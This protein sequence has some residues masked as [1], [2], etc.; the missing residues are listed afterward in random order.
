MPEEMKRDLLETP[1]FVLEMAGSFRLDP[2][3]V[4]GHI[5]ARRPAE[6]TFMAQNCIMAQQSLDRFIRIRNS[7]E[8]RGFRAPGTIATEPTKPPTSLRD[9]RTGGM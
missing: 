7:Y 3:E 9:V 1:A 6:V 8:R 5:Q 2:V 4:M